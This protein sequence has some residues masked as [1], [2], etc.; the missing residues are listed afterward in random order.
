M[1]Y[2]LKVSELKLQLASLAFNILLSHPL[3]EDCSPY[4]Q[5]WNNEIPVNYFTK[6]KRFINSSLFP[7]WQILDENEII[8]SILFCF[9]CS[10]L[11]YVC[12]HFRHHSEVVEWMWSLLSLHPRKYFIWHHSLSSTLPCL[13]R[14]NTKI[15]IIRNYEW[16]DLYINRLKEGFLF[17]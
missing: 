14:E 8:F 6:F 1:L 11:F 13:S 3:T 7:P 10:C 5:E 4:I 12:V 17:P 2:V 16:K 9:E 15:F